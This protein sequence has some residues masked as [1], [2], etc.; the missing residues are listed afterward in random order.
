MH[1]KLFFQ[2]EEDL[3]LPI[4]YNHIL[5]AFIYN[6]IDERLAAFLHDQGFTVDGRAFKLFTFSRV[7][8]SFSIDRERQV[9]HFGREFQL[10]LASPLVE[11]CQSVCQRVMQA[12]VLRLGQ[13]S[14]RAVEAEV[15]EPHVSGEEITVR[16]LSPVTVYSTLL[17]PSGQKYTCYFQPG[18]KDFNNLITTNLARKFQALNP[19]WPIPEGEVHVSVHSPKQ[20]IVEYKG[21]VIKGYSGV[22]HL[23]GPA[24]LL[25]MALDAGLGSKN[26]QGF[27]F[28]ELYPRR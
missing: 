24:L 7:Q 17:K 15:S 21:F 22:F 11:F 26:S 5:Q 16:S 2:S 4:Q 14:V 13:T 25:Q 28:I 6:A 8:G 27:G 9:I 19:D 23:C 3:L 12:E 10:S 18:E 1:I 20:N